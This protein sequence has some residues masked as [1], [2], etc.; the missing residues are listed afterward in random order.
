MRDLAGTLGITP[1][2]LYYHFRNKDAIVLEVLAARRRDL[3]ELLGWI[4]AQPPAPDLVRRA[5]LRWVEQTTGDDL[6]GL[7]FAEANGPVL[8]RLLKDDRV[9]LPM[10]FQEVVDA[11]L[12]HDASTAE[13]LLVAM[14]FDTPSAVLLAA[15]GA[16]IPPD[17]LLAAAHR[18]SCLLTTAQ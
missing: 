16:P 13:R 5:A 2:A 12:P 14:A 4:R 10:A 9:N 6:D 1:S 17:V 15:H 11:L 8:Q 7:R 3:D 18:A